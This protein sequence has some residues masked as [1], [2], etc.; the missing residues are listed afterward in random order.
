MYRSCTV[1]AFQ[2]SFSS[3]SAC[4]SHL[5]V[6]VRLADGSG[7]PHERVMGLYLGRPA[8]AE[9]SDVRSSSTVRCNG[10]R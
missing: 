4:E 8:I 3:G 1:V 10:G 5:C 2:R 7:A 9:W 6:F